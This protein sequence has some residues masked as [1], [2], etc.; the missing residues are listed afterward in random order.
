MKVS[1]WKT[2]QES[3]Q[4]QSLLQK[5]DLNTLKKTDRTKEPTRMGKLLIQSKVSWFAAL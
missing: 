2:K 5:A 1:A 3:I 4:I